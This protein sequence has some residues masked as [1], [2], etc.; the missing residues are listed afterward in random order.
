M[1][2]NRSYGSDR[3]V[4]IICLKKVKKKYAVKKKKIRQNVNE[5][6]I[7]QQRKSVE[8]NEVK[9][10]KNKNARVKRDVEV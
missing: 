10:G 1:S 7:I 2:F 4:Y 3:W 6:L 8:K 9:K 5:Q